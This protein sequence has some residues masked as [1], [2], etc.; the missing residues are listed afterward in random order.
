MNILATLA[1]ST[2]AFSLAA[3]GGG[4]TDAAVSTPSPS[5]TAA[6][7]PSLQVSCPPSSGAG[8]D[9][10][11]TRAFYVLVN[12]FTASHLSEVDLD[13]DLDATTAGPFTITLSAFQGGF[14][15][16]L[17]GTATATP[18]L[19]TSPNYSLTKFVFSGNPSV[20]PDGII[21]F[22]MTINSGTGSVFF[23]TGTTNSS[24]PMNETNGS[25]G[26]LDTTRAAGAPGALIYGY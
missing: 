14:N 12:A 13:L 26:T 2:C 7:T 15:G 8:G 21:A 10:V 19:A 20:T 16:A 18:T 23:D 11:A 17:I 22:T 3:C 24:C 1:L 5:P 6:P 25:T 9:N 4:T